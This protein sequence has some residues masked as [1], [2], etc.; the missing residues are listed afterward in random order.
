M[1]F[2]DFSKVQYIKTIDT[3]ELVKIG[4]FN[5][6]NNLELKY[7]RLTVYVESM[8]LTTEQIRINIYSDIDCT[9]KLFSSDWCTLSDISGLS[10]RWIGWV[11]I[12]FNRQPI[13]KLL[14]YYAA[15]E[16]QNYTRTASNYIGCSFDFPFPIYENNE[17]DFYNHPL[18]FQLF[19]YTDRQGS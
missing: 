1:A 8:A 12:D 18:Q 5:T 10:S 4:S 3:G 2:K 6:V 7:M 19:G 15:I 11:R 13:N 16:S 14:T 9:S 17:N